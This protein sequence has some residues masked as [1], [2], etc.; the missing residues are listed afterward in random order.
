[1]KFQIQKKNREKERERNINQNVHFLYLNLKFSKEKYFK[2]NI[3][4][5]DFFLKLEVQFPFEINDFRE[6]IYLLFFSLCLFFPPFWQVGGSVP[7]TDTAA[8]VKLLKSFLLFATETGPTHADE[9]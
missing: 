8:R 4:R 7:D 9:I 6:T 3:L 2:S 5:N 1:M